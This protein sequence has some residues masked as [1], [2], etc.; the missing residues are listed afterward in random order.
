MQKQPTM[1]LSKM[2]SLFKLLEKNGTDVE[3]FLVSG[4][5]NPKHRRSPD[6]R[7]SLTQMHAITHKAAA[8]M[9]D[10]HLG[11]HQGEIYSGLPSILCYVTMNCHDLAEALEKCRTYQRIADETKEL[12]IIYEGDTA[13]IYATI[14][15]DEFDTDVHLSDAMLCSLFMFFKFLTG[16]KIAL[17]EVRFRHAALKEISEYRRIFKCPVK[18]NCQA[19][20]IVMDKKVLNTHILHPNRELLD[21][22]EKQAAEVLRRRLSTESYSGCVSHMMIQ[23]FREAQSPSLE[24]IAKKMAT[25]VR[26]LQMKLKE[27]GTTYR[28]LLN[29]NRKNLAME[30]LKDIDV[31]ICEI[32]YLLG[33]SEPST[34]HRFF[35]KLTGHTPLQ[36]RENLISFK[37]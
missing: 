18:F 1:L 19:N 8:L 9:G 26:K 21:L 13:I 4:G 22:F 23:F 24:A 15:N 37:N 10:S 6:S 35:K 27:E 30:Y 32:S 36:H 20:A 29:T 12:N 3:E 34:F 7:I 2:T 14:I 28:E 31:S 5:I 16:K 33:F 17:K 11:L 25:S